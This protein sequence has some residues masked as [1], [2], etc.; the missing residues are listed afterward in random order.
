MRQYKYAAMAGAPNFCIFTFI[1]TTMIWITS[2]L[3][4]ILS[5]QLEATYKTQGIA[6][7]ILT[8]QLKNA[9]KIKMGFCGNLSSNLTK[10][11]SNLTWHNVFHNI[12]SMSLLNCVHENLSPIGLYILIP[13]CEMYICIGMVFTYQLNMI[14]FKKYRFYSEYSYLGKCRITMEDTVLILS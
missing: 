6:Q 14:L 2:T 4:V 11:Y 1:I 5:Q 13:I 9:L 10:A 7:H 8:M 3:S 12:L